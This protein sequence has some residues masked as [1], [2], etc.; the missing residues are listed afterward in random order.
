VIGQ[1]SK[2]FSHPNNLTFL[3]VY[4]EQRG[5]KNRQSQIHYISLMLATCFGV[6]EKSSG[7]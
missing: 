5:S 1:A 4:D 2:G 6:C 3:V 7:N